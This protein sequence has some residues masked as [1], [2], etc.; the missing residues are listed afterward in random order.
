MA[1]LRGRRRIT[2]I[3]DQSSSNGTEI[4]A[5]LSEITSSFTQ[6][7]LSM[8]DEESKLTMVLS[9]ISYVGRYLVILNNSR[10]DK[11]TRV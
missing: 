11:I 2:L 9:F 3:R 8:S 10:R 5:D 1:S 7:M 6:R 4:K